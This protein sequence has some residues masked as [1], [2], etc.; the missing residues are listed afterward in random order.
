MIKKNLSNIQKRPSIILAIIFFSVNS[1]NNYDLRE[2]LENPGGR[3][4]IFADRLY[5]FV[6]S[7]ST[8]GDM[9]GLTASGCAGQGSQRADCYCQ[10]TAVA[11]NLRKSSSS[12]FVAWLSD[13]NDDMSCRIVAMTSTGCSPNGTPVWHT[14]VNQPIFS[15]YG[16]PNGIFFAVLLAPISYT[17]AKNLRPPTFVHTGTL[18]TG[19]AS[20][21]DSCNNWVT[22]N[23][24]T[25]LSG[26]AD[27]SSDTW[28]Q[29]QSDACE[30]ELPIY[31][32]A[33]P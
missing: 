27:S 29:D 5:A 21:G 22:N 18:A 32:F 3:S 30:T 26:R 33:V 24:S 31:C 6:T 7:A 8:K 16:S 28:S 4:E 14:T 17:E 10:Q 2:K 15:G 9:A 1:C 19:A 12:R 25:G 23:G 20:V 11:A 13:G